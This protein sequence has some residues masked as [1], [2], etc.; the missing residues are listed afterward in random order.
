MKT[1]FGFQMVRVG[2]LAM[3]AA[4]GWASQI[5]ALPVEL[6]GV[7]DDNS[8]TIYRYDLN[9]NPLTPPSWSSGN[10]PFVLAGTPTGFFVARYDFTTATDIRAYNRNGTVNTSFGTGGDVNITGYSQLIRS[11][12]M[13]YDPLADKLYLG[14]RWQG[15]TGSGMPVLAFSSTGAQSLVGTIS[16]PAN[17]TEFDVTV[18]PNGTLYAGSYEGNKI[19]KYSPG[20]ISGS[21]TNFTILV[22][23][24][25]GVWAIAADTNYVYAVLNVAG[26]NI[27]RYNS[28]TGVEDGTWSVS[29]PDNF[30]D[31]VIGDSYLFAED[32]AGDLHRYNT[33]GS[34]GGTVI[35]SMSPRF[36]TLAIEIPEPGMVALGG[37]GLLLLWPRRS[38]R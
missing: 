11:H 2:A 8:N 38:R 16:A 37:L 3:A 10:D 14:G 9:G 33:L 34:P 1:H 5:M 17:D 6:L 20:S 13:S 29:D 26:T 23:A 32:N 27:K 25:V 24:P 30:S 22:T 19:Y 36:D 28:T 18:D 31:L 12:G 35:V 4:L 15:G 7:H 21:T